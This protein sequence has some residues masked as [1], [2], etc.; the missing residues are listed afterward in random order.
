MPSPFD[1]NDPL[2]RVA[3]HVRRRVAEI[4]AD[5]V[6]MKDY[7]S[8]DPVEQVQAIMAGLAVGMIGICFAHIR[9]AGR[10]A[11]MEAIVD[12]LP[13]AREQAE[14]IMKDAKLQ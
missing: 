2:N 10:D 8:L 12:Y 6:R 9:D 4:V 14:G 7:R 11:M 5:V 13:Q 1:A 3:D